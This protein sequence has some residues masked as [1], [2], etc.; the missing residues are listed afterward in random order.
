MTIYIPETFKT[1]GSVQPAVEFQSPLTPDTATIGTKTIASMSEG[2]GSI[3][4]A[5]LK[6]DVDQI[7]RA[8]ELRQKDQLVKLKDYTT[9]LT[10]GN[11]EDGTK[12]FTSYLG[13]DAIINKDFNNLSIQDYYG[14]KFNDFK[15]KLLSDLP[16]IAKKGFEEK[17]TIVETSF[18]ENILRHG[19][20]EALR[21]E[22]DVSQKEL[23]RIEK[24]FILSETPDQRNIAIQELTMSAKQ[25]S[26]LTG[27][28]NTDKYLS[29][30]VSQKVLM[31]IN[32]GN[33]D[34]AISLF[35]EGKK[36]LSSD[37]IVK[38]EPQI[39]RAI[40]ENVV[41]NFSEI[42]N[43]DLEI[44]VANS[45]GINHVFD[46]IKFIESGGRQIDKNGFP[47]ISRAGAVGIAQ[48]MPSTGEEM[49]KEL[50]IDWD[51]KKF[52][53]DPEY[54]AT[55]GKAYLK[56]SLDKFKNVDKAIASYNAG[57]SAV[58]K[59]I[60][61][62]KIETGSKEKWIE[63]VP[64]ETQDYL[65]KVKSK[66][67]TSNP[68]MLPDKRIYVNQ[69]NQ[70]FLESNP[71]AT[72]DQKKLLNAKLV[73]NYDLM[74]SEIGDQYNNIKSQLFQNIQGGK[75]IDSS[76]LNILPQKDQR[77][78]L[79][80]QSDF[81]QGKYIPT[82]IDL[83]TKLSSDAKLLSNYNLL[84]NKNKFN[85]QDYSYLEKLQKDINDNPKVQTNIQV[86]NRVLDDY[87][88]LSTDSLSSETK[89]VTLEERKKAE[90]MV[91]DNL[92]RVQSKQKEP[93]TIDQVKEITNKTLAPIVL[94]DPKTK[95]STFI[96][97]R[98]TE[99][100]ISS[101]DPQKDE[102]KNINIPPFEYNKYLESYVRT[103]GRKPTD[104]ELNNYY[105]AVR[106]GRS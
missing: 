68:S 45:T 39:K 54:N 86:I 41:N 53:E 71:N 6:T 78:I 58:E 93:L 103:F 94:S 105:R 63:F 81:L 3:G 80:Y 95:G 40:D 72:E 92:E 31:T 59:A 66:M 83:Y 24:D 88:Y 4:K 30:M 82:D 5:L 16:E 29:D 100:L 46:S 104:Q 91:Y 49:A 57:I 76:L 99:P 60:E 64:K 26:S 43:K 20:K 23:Q 35:N 27:Q 98:I 101:E 37:A 48:V 7:N 51:I 25:L 65:E 32:T 89:K 38:L 10:Y 9:N 42:Y 14:S 28:D 8:V 69:G 17:A 87:G 77:E 85:N 61:I 56:K 19:Q 73:Q 21:Y 55:L 97:K 11:Q 90:Q 33:T 47:I 102:Y 13:K 75:Q 74:S 1:S 70:S 12:G 84:A 96:F 52:K 22:I 50:G 34:Q 67:N 62:A 106:L 36:Y 2:L 18:F 44:N 79:S 15:N